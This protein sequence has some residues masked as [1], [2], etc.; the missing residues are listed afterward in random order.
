VSSETKW[1]KG[2]WSVEEIKSDGDYGDGGPDSRTGFT[3]Y[4]VVDSEGRPL[5]DALNRDG[6]VS[7]VHEEGYDDEDGGRVFAWDELARA[8]MT[9]AAA[10]PKLYEALAEFVPEL[11][12]G[13]LT[14]AERIEM[15]RTA[16]ASARGEG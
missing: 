3:T 8:D 5:F 7:C 1:T 2:E 4:A 16:L 10:S 14:E 15:A 11:Q 9:L 6:R 12:S 13:K